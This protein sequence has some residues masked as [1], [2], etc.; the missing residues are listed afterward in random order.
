MYNLQ[1]AELTQA[2]LNTLYVL[3]RKQLYIILRVHY[4]AK[5][6]SKALYQSTFGCFI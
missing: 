4:P 1:T 5:S 3:H 6:F 2:H